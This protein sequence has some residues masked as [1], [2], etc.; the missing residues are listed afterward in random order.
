MTQ[1]VNGS[2]VWPRR[3]PTALPLL[4]TKYGQVCSLCIQTY[5]GR[6]WS[7]SLPFPSPPFPFPPAERELQPN[8]YVPHFCILT[9]KSTVAGTVFVT[10]AKKLSNSGVNGVKISGTVAYSYTHRVRGCSFP[11]M[12]PTYVGTAMVWFRFEPLKKHEICRQT[13]ESSLR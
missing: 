6:K 9:A 7:L 10:F 2:T 1:S 4:L 5:L 3:N 8:F 13:E 12:R 11:H